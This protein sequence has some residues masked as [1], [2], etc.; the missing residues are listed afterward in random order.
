MNEI[1]AVE[2]GNDLNAPRQD[3]FIEFFDFLMNRHK[4]GVGI[5]TL[6]EQHNSFDHVVIVEDVPVSAM[7]RFADSPKAYFGSL[8]NGG[9]IFDPDRGSALSLDDGPLDIPGG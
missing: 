1:A 6:S 8:R 4:R 5:S 2:K 3:T 9:Y 7:N